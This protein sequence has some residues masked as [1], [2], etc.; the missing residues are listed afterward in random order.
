MKILVVSDT[1][2]VLDGVKKAISQI[3]QPDLVIHL[4]DILRQ[5]EKLKEMCGCPVK[6][7]QGNCDFHSENPMADIVEFGNNR[8][9][10]TH[11]HYY[12]VD[13]GIDR[14]CYAADGNNCNFAMYGHTHE[15]EIVDNK[16]IM[17]LNP[18]SL[19]RP[20]QFNRKKSYIVIDVDDKGEAKAELRYL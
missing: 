2:G 3:G 7:V 11:G 1:H 18:G 10:I 20:R 6:I 14:L 15:P 8:A 16:G 19:T 9:F 17:V 4:G 5:D 12:Q 13:W